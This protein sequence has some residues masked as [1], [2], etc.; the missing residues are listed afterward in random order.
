M[1]KK[2]RNLPDAGFPLV[3]VIVLTYNPVWPKLA[4]TLLS[5]VRQQG[6]SLEIL[7]ADDGSGD[8]LQ[9]RAKDFLDSRGFSRAVCLPS[10]TNRGTVRNFLR[11][12]EAASG[13]YVYAISPGDFFFNET[14]LARM[15]AFAEERGAELCFGEAAFYRRST[16]NTGGRSFCASCRSTKGPSP[17]VPADRLQSPSRPALYRSLNMG[18]QK[19]A[20][21]FL[22][23]ILGAAYLRRRDT[24]LKYLRRIAP[25]V[26][27][28]EDTPTTLLALGDGIPVHWFEAP[29]VWYEC[30]EGISSGGGESPGGSGGSGSAGNAAGAVNSG[31]SGADHWRRLLDQ[32]YRAAYELLLEAH[33]GDPYARAA[34]RYRYE[35][36]Q[37]ESVW[38]QFLTHPAVVA[39]FY[40]RLRFPVKTW[41]APAGSLE[42][43]TA[44]LR[45]ADSL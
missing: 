34:W 44:F 36:N 13:K 6:I 22:D 12:V 27:Y 7:L 30:G 16:G 43:L 11:G 1:P 17:C 24:A 28:A 42:A 25:R 39:R 8:N 20:F 14:V 4:A 37:Q 32:D 29:V 19:A 41:E 33:P 9:S 26:K 15:T 21:F 10:D 5:A 23:Y 40:R 31:G 2:E 35:K 38:R 3:S 45:E 18:N